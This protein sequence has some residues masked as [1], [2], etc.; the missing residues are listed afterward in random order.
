M[1]DV[2]CKITYC[3]WPA[4]WEATPTTT[5]LKEIGYHV[6]I[7]DPVADKVLESEIMA[8][9]ISEIRMVEGANAAY[10]IVDVRSALVDMPL[11]WH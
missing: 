7:S 5:R 3:L 1:C 9:G 2:E 4:H 6:R 11:P 8:H 10:E